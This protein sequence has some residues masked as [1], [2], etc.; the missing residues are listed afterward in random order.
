MRSWRSIVCSCSERWNRHRKAP[1]IFD[2]D[3]RGGVF[4]GQGACV[5]EHQG[6]LVRHVSDFV[7]HFGVLLSAYSHPIGSSPT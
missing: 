7:P 2:A 1:V 5:S 6:D 3:R 4:A